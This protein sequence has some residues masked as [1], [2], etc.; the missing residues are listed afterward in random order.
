MKFKELLCA[1]SIKQ[2]LNIWLI[3][4]RT[5]NLLCTVA[6]HSQKTPYVD[7]RTDLL[8]RPHLVIQMLKAPIRNNRNYITS[9]AQSAFPSLIINRLLIM[10]N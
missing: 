8:Q 5:I 7:R 6:K 2:R 3:S 9:S 4:D 1:A 10:N